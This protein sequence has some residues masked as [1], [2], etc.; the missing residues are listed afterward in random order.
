VYNSIKYHL[1]KIVG[2]DFLLK[3]EA[4]LRKTYAIFYLGKK[5]FC[6]VCLSRLRTFVELP[7]NDKLCPVCGS[8][9]RTRRLCK[10][11]NEN[12]VLQGKVLHFSPSRGL[13]RYLRRQPN[14]EY[15]SSDF[16]N[17]FL[18]DY[19]YDITAI[20][21]KSETFD[22]IICYHILEHIDNDQLAISELFRVLKPNG[23]IYIQTPFKTGNTYENSAI[24]SP[25]ERLIHFG[26][27][28][29][30]RVYSVK[31]LSQRLKSVGFKVKVKKFEG[32]SYNH[33]YGLNPSETILM[34][35]K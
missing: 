4:L 29:H 15:Y 11:L 16:K 13:Y 1:R 14:I 35:N 18:S 30:I 27:K 22:L 10:L 34:A 31:G 32:L 19:Q 24:T 6:P 5:H 21:Q 3:N 7:N 9:S 23:R 25:Q 28:D 8:L 26:Q 33:E 17:E 12:H 20:D 2:Q